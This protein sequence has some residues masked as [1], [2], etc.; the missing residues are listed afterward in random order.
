MTGR[1]S[2]IL[3][4]MDIALAIHADV[5]VYIFTHLHTALLTEISM[6]DTNRLQAAKEM[7]GGNLLW[8]VLWFMPCSM[9]PSVLQANPHNNFNVLFQTQFKG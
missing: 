4:A 9:K 6:L 2:S 1:T 8:A 5:I 7:A 3:G